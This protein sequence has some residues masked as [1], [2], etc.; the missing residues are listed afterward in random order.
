MLQNSEVLVDVLV[1]GGVG[2][3][4]L[5]VAYFTDSD[6]SIVYNGANTYVYQQLAERLFTEKIR[7]VGPSL[8]HQWTATSEQ[9][10]AKS[11]RDIK[12]EKRDQAKREAADS[13]LERF[14][15]SLEV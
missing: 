8:S 13:R 1:G 5:E 7:E 14:R 15:R 4:K 10:L 6:H 2:P 12:M 9:P 11:K 3:D